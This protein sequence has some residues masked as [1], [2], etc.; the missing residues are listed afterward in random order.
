[1]RNG[2]SRG[3]SPSM[4]DRRELAHGTRVEMEHTSDLRIAQRIA[5]DHLMEDPMYY[6]KLASIHLGA[7]GDVAAVPGSGPYFIPDLSH[8]QGDRPN[9]NAIAATPRMVGCIIKATQGVTYAPSW[10]VNN[11][12]RVRAAGGSRYGSSWFRGCYHFA[13]PNPSGATQADFM[14]AHVQKA[15]GWG[16]GDMSP[17]WDLEGSAWSSAQQILD[18]SSSFRERIQQRLGKT[19]VLYTGSAWRNFGIKTKAGFS[20][21]WSTHLNKM[22]PYG[23]PNSSYALWQYVGTGKYY[24]PATAA[25][26]YPTGVTGLPNSLDMNVVMSGGAPANSISDVRR[27]L[28]GRGGLL[29]PLLIG[30]ALFA[31]YLLARRHG[32]ESLT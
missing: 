1:M 15:G 4:F 26:G 5:M 32:R 14:L 31:G 17:A 13:A 7:L 18:V 9:F 22:E 21:L 2:L 23:W 8:W 19:P 3:M 11:W 12:N 25:L 10:F 16:D 6:R 20:Q 27:V 29:I 28:T 24:N 30:G